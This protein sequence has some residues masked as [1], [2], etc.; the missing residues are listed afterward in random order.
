MLSSSSFTT[1][2]A[3]I[4]SLQSGYLLTQLQLQLL[5]MLMAL[6]AVALTTLSISCKS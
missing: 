3:Y 1:A 2:E 4:S 6:E 5:G